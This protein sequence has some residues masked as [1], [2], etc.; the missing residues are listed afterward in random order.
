MGFLIGVN[1]EGKI[2]FKTNKQ[3][4]AFP[5]HSYSSCSAALA[6]AHRLG[7]LVDQTVAVCRAHWKGHDFSI[8]NNQ[9]MTTVA[10]PNWVLF[11][12]ELDWWFKGGTIVWR[13]HQGCSLLLT[14]YRPTLVCGFCSHGPRWLLYLRQ[15]VAFWTEIRK[16]PRGGDSAYSRKAKLSRKFQLS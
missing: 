7:H 3:T 9:N 8:S 10:Q 4:Q 16:W 11:C 15:P 12:P 14:S 13:N 1:P 2:I 6:G 5:N